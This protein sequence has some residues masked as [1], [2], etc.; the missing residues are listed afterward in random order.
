MPLSA[1]FRPPIAERLR[2]L[3]GA[4]APEVL[5]AVDALADRYASLRRRAARQPCGPETVLLITYADQ[6]QSEGHPSLQVLDAFLREFGCDEVFSVVHILPCFPCSSD[7]GFS[8]IDY[9]SIDP[10]LGDWDDVRTLAKSFDLMLDLVVNHCSQQSPWFRAYLRGEEPYAR[11]FIEVD[12]EA[13]FSAVTRPR[14]SPLLTPF[15]TSRGTKHLWTT[16]SADQVDLNFADPAVLLEM[17]DVLLFYIEHGTRA[18]RLDA[19]GFLWKQ[20]GTRSMHLPQTHAV[21]KIMRA[22]LDELAPGTVLLTETNVPHEENLSYFGAGDE[23]HAVYNFSLAPLLLDAFLTEDAGPFSRWLATLRY[24]GA[25][26]TLLNFTASHDGIGVRPLEGLVSQ[27]RIDRLVAEVRRRGGLVSMRQKPDGSESPYELNVSYLSAL[28]EPGPRGL[29]RER[30]AR[31]FLT[32][33]GVMLALRGVPAV[34]FHSLVGTPNDLQG[35]QQTGRNRSINRRKFELDELRQILD[36]INSLERLVFDGYLKMLRIRAR[37]PALH[38]HAEQAVVDMGQKSVIA[39]E[40]IGEDARGTQRILVLAN[41]GREPAGI[42][43]SVAP[44]I[45]LEKDL[46][47]GRSVEGAHY[48]L[49]PYDLAWLASM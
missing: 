45:A 22:L 31:R 35:V 26:M 47:T 32:S 38:P 42:D 6:V 37:Q 4:Q 5:R 28:G 24:P 49:G 11:Y 40:R 30:H 23:A 34:Y 44:G 33:Q 21:V 7:D 48:K 12:P 1:A 36:N 10:A 14:S 19:I 2:Q 18:I 43:L 41:V 9:R 25:G 3:Y 29:P 20:I 16:F 8:V 17:L 15:E 46:L 39:L 13:D 27:E